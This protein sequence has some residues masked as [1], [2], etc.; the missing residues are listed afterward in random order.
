LGFILLFVVMACGSTAAIDLAAGEKERQTLQTLLCAPVRPL[1][2]VAGKYLVVVLLALVGG[3]M[4]LVSLSLALSSRLA[5]P[6]LHVQLSIGLPTLAG[7]FW[8]LVPL[9]LFVSALVLG[10]ALMARTA[11]EAQSYVNPAL[12]L[13]LALAGIGCLPGLQLTA[14]TALVP[15]ANVVLVTR[16][17]FTGALAPAAYALVLASTLAFAA[18]ALVGTAQL[19]SDEEVQLSSGTWRSWVRRR[20]K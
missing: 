10:L 8:A 4:N 16:A 12:Y 2:I 11:R 5:D 19:F 3:V 1:E 20:N 6:R 18:L 13:L 14:R 7:V 9:V 17:L 15:I